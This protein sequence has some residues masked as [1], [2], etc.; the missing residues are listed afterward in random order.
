MFVCSIRASTIKF[1]S[2]ITLLCII[3]FIIASSSSGATVY[4]SADGTEIKYGG[5]RD[6]DDRVAFIRCFGLEV[7]EEPLEEESFVMPKNFDKIILGYNQLQKEQG[8]D[9]EK[10]TRKRV[11]HY[12]YKVTNYDCDSEVHVNLLMHRSKVIAA[13]ISST[14]KDGF[15]LPL[16]GIDPSKIK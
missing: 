5:I 6:N 11:T 14:E 10:Y 1:F 12:S 13:D 8:L 4:A 3:A 15:V 9:L 7:V 16:T 2:L